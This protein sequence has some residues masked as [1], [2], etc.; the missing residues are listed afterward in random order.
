[1]N[2]N[3][4]IN[5]PSSTTE[6]DEGATT[7]KEKSRGSTSPS[8][9]DIFTAPHVKA[10]TTQR[11]R[12]KAVSNAQG[13]TIAKE[14]ALSAENEAGREVAMGKTIPPSKNVCLDV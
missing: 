4:P 12:K 10:K 6:D 2:R 7:P 5:V 3:D 8:S 1:M 13:K 11:P 9:N 14:N